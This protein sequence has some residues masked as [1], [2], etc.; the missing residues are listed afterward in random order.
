MPL[1][2]IDIVAY[3]KLNSKVAAM[4]GAQKAGVDIHS[5]LLATEAAVEVSRWGISW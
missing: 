1:P 2:G 5:M 3:A 4:A